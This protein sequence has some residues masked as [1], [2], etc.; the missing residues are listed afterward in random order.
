MGHRAWHF[1]GEHV[2]RSWKDIAE[3][4]VT[5]EEARKRSLSRLHDDVVDVD[6]EAQKLLALIKFAREAVSKSMVSGMGYKQD[7]VSKQDLS[8][9]HDLS[10]MFEKV[11]R[12][13]GALDRTADLRSKKLTRTQ[14]LD[15]AYKLVVSLP[16]ADRA[17]W[18][19]K[20]V[21]HH[22]VLCAGL[23]RQSGVKQ[24]QEV[25][26][27]ITEPPPPEES[28]LVEGTVPDDHGEP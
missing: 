17:R 8:A 9:L 14:Y 1:S 18:L 23:V 16:W 7:G 11:S 25:M 20:A 4:G 13:I 24:A 12:A 19:R 3:E 21:D 28:A 2:T 10:A 26:P 5:T 27:S 6:D 15:V 22:N